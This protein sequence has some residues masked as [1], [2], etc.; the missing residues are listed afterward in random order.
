VDLQPAAVVINKAQLPEPVHEKADS[1][2]RG[3]DHFCQGLLTDLGNHSLRRA[4][5]A[6]MGKQQKDSGQPLFA[7]I[8]KLVNQIFFVSNVPRE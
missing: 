1:R 5:L 7:R 3:A 8:E 2:T 4:F 6:K